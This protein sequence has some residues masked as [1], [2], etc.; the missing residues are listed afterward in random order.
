MASIKGSSGKPALTFDQFLGP[1]VGAAPGGSEQLQEPEQR[2]TGRLLPTTRKIQGP[3]ASGEVR[4]E[5]A[6]AR[7][8]AYDA[9]LGPAKEA[10]GTAEG[11]KLAGKGVVAGAVQVGGPVAGAFA[12]G[13]LGFM[14][15]APGGP[16]VQ[17]VTTGLGALGGFLYGAYASDKATTE[18][19]RRGLALRPENAPE[20]VRPLVVGGESLGASFFMG[21]QVFAAGRSALRLP[22][23]RFGNVVNRILDT[24]RDQP[25]YFLAAEAT[26]ATSAA[27]AEALAES[28]KPGDLMARVTAGTVG[29]VVNPTAITLSIAKR[30][31][32]LANQMWQSLSP[33]ARQTAAGKALKE[34]LV[35][36]EEDPEILWNLIDQ[37][38]LHTTGIPEFDSTASQLVDSPALATL[39]ANLAERDRS[40]QKDRALAGQRGLDAVAR[41]LQAIA[42]LDESGRLQAGIAARQMRYVNALDRLLNWAE[43]DAVAATNKLLEGTNINN[44]AEFYARRRDLSLQISEIYDRALATARQVEKELWEKASSD[45][46]FVANPRRIRQ[47]YSQLRGDML[48]TERLPD[49][50]E[51]QIALFRHSQTLLQ[52]AQRGLTTTADGEAITPA[53]IRAAEKE[54]S[55]GNLIKFRSRM[56]SHA[57]SAARAASAGTEGAADRARW[58]GTLAEAA[59]DD[60]V[61]HSAATRARPTGQLGRI[62][63]GRRILPPEAQTV[64][65]DAREFSNAVAGTFSRSYIGK[66]QQVGPFGEVMPPEVLAQ[67][68]FKVGDDLTPIRSRALEE[69]TR[70]APSRKFGDDP[71]LTA[72]LDADAEAMMDA[73]EQIMRMLVD[74]SRTPK[75]DLNPDKMR[76]IKQSNGWIQERFPELWKD[77][78]GALSSTEQFLDWS[79]RIRADKTR[80]TATQA[81]A[82]VLA[83]DSPADA[84]RAALAGAKPV[85]KLDEM[86]RLAK[87]TNTL[88]GFRGA[89]WDDAFRAAER[90]D[91]SVDISVFLARLQR[92]IRPGLPSIRDF[93]IERN[94]MTADQL[95]WID[96]ATEIVQRI[97]QAQ[98]TLPT[99]E[100][101]IGPAGSVMDLLLRMAGAEAGRITLR[102]SQAIT[103]QTQAGATGSVLIVS[104]AGAKAMQQ[105]MDRIP[106][107]K[108]QQILIDALRGEALPG[109]PR[110][111]LLKLLLEKGGTPEKVVENA[112]R[113]HAYAWQAGYLALDDL[114]ERRN[115]EAEDRLEHPGDAD[116]LGADPISF[117]NAGPPSEDGPALSA[118]EQSALDEPTTIARNPDNIFFL[119]PAQLQLQRNLELIQRGNLSPEERSVAVENVREAFR[120]TQQTL[121]TLAVTDIELIEKKEAKVLERKAKKLRERYNALV[122]PLNNALS[123]LE[124]QTPGTIDPAELEGTRQAIAAHGKILDEY[125]E[126]QAE[127]QELQRRARRRERDPAPP[128]SNEI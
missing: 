28:Q 81:F 120:N 25:K 99:G 44:P 42:S 34:F 9:I 94:V 90:A 71:E 97:Q 15:G 108:T 122:D 74:G 116:V 100:V 8:L 24:A 59:L 127:I 102:G 96:S 113:L 56:L 31:L 105:L 119:E 106:K 125:L 19:E 13:E 54:T 20:G 76:H 126:L 111:S 58:F 63:A 14:I 55:A 124:Q 110:F 41:A 38:R 103:G 115:Q 68:A 82:G 73:Q 69:A 35:A 107:L 88:D 77:M 3:E 95:G 65:D 32:G 1:A 104:G 87:G 4:S 21:S 79:A 23:S 89:I 27:L 39:E 30:G 5:G 98:S 7:Q 72:A 40:F 43:R 86:Y 53:M 47:V 62:G 93:L 46:E 26:S 57:R 83:V 45:F 112:L 101:P 75:G 29:G 37:A 80:I 61:R 128:R 22:D 64:Y 121:E 10:G 70:F 12:G 123:R 16:A 17:T 6:D 60:L 48:T 66:L 51:D 92:P 114:L 91:G 49:L 18:L 36:A 2:P 118:E 52:R 11:L 67:Q 50:I 117:S 85:S 84:V 78:E 33:A 109:Q